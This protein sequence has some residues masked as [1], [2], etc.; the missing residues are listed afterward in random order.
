MS[1]K[2]NNKKGDNKMENQN[3]EE[4]KELVNEVEE[5]KEV[6]ETEEVE[7]V[8]DPEV[9]QEELEAI[10]STGETKEDF[11]GESMNAPEESEDETEEDEHSGAISPAV[12]VGCGKLN[13]RENPSKDAK[14]VC[15][16][17]L[18]QELTVD[19]DKST[20]EFYKVY[21]CVKEVLYEGYCV[22]QFISIK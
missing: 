12:V 13:V 14:V 10:T 11:E 7:E 2:K 21:T 15:V 17:N 22:K 16:M 20:E 19:L 9:T 4:V 1:K 6:E 5:T 18:G 3:I 8:K